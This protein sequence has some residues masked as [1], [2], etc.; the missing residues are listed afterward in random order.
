MELC[1]AVQTLPWPWN[2][3]ALHIQLQTDRK[4]LV[5]E[6][7]RWQFNWY[8]A[9]SEVEDCLHCNGSGSVPPWNAYDDEDMECGRCSGFGFLV[10]YT[11]NYRPIGRI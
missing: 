3:P 11:K 1:Y 6:R 5:D 8:G 7:Y 4:D 9:G 2:Y 10:S